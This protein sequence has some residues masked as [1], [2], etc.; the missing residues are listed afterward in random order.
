MPLIDSEPIKK[1]IVD[2]LNS[3][4]AMEAFGYDAIEILAQIEYA[5]E[6]VVRCK[7]CQYYRKQAPIASP[8]CVR[9]ANVTSEDSFCSYG[10]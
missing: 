10:R 5:P 8:W 7:D 2:R 3:Q 4:N 1:F 9:W 6:A